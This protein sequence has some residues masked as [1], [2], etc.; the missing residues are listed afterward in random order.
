VAPVVLSATRWW[1]ALASVAAGLSLFVVA[2]V[3]AV[4]V[5][6]AR[7]IAAVVAVRHRNLARV[8]RIGSLVA[9]RVIVFLDYQ[10]IYKGARES[11]HAAGAPGGFGQVHP[12]QL[13]ALV[14]NQIPDGELKQVRVYRGI[15]SNQRDPRGYGAVRKQTAA[16]VKSSPKVVVFHRPLQYLTGMAPREK[17]I[18]VQ[19]AIDFVV[20]AVKGD[21][22]IGVLF[23]ADTDLVPALDAVC[24][25]SR[26]G[27]PAARVAGWDGPN[28]KKRCIRP[29]GKRQ[30]PCVWLSMSH[31][32]G[33]NDHNH[34]A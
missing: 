4:D 5:L 15:P 7:G 30:A 9:E 34:Y 1:I 16:W 17:G 25:L 18:D 19:L 24:D 31:Y 22:D 33:A 6:W 32:N 14:A 29:N 11:F 21:Y 26:H 20:M 2:R 12:L 23:S 13:G 8:R 28:D 3:R 10:N 27:R